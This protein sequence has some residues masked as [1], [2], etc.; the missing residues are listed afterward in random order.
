MVAQATE[1]RSA[2]FHLCGPAGVCKMDY[3]QNQKVFSNLLPSW[4]E[5]KMWQQLHINWSYSQVSQT[6]FDY[7]SVI[8][9]YSQFL[10]IC[11]KNA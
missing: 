5:S 8:I 1:C 2:A 6:K 11:Y 4:Q 10:C 9:T 7:L 3:K